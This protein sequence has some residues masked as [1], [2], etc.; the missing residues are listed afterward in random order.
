MEQRA[1][2]RGE[3]IATLSRVTLEHL[4]R[5]NAADTLTVALRA[6][7][8][9]RPAQPF[10]VS[11]ALA[12]CVVSLLMAKKKHASELTTDEAIRRIFGKKA[13]KKLHALVG[14]LDAGKGRKK[15][16]KRDGK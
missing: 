16:Q 5:F 8:A 4:A 2:R 6:L 9:I 11:A 3:L 14:Q 10:K 1:R 7:Y 15:R 13:V 12:G